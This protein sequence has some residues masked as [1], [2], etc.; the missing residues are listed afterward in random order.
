M[1]LESRAA[2][3]LD[4]SGATWLGE[5]ARAEFTERNLALIGAL[6]AITGARKMYEALTAAA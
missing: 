1:S 3:A 6:K 5:K 2:L 4:P